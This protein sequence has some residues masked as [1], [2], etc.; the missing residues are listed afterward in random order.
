MNIQSL[1]TEVKAQWDLALQI[2]FDNIKADYLAWNRPIR[3]DDGISEQ[4]RN[5]SYVRFATGLRIVE[6]TLYYKVISGSG[7]H[8]FIVKADGQFKAGDILKAATYK[9][10]AKNKARG[11]LFTGYRIQWTGADYLR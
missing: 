7:V 8:S 3:A 9:A 1:N 5:E 2:Y 10:P 4:I 6:T 11:N